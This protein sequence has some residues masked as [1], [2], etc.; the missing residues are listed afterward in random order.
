[1]CL[2]QFCVSHRARCRNVAEHVQHPTRL[3]ADRRQSRN[4]VSRGG[5]TPLYPKFGFN[6]LPKV[7]FA[8]ANETPKLLWS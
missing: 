3:T 8:A 1:M 7:L 4:F 2:F 6:Y 5:F